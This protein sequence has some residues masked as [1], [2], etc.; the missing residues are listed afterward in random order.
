MRPRGAP[1]YIPAH[2]ISARIDAC[3]Q[4]R[5]SAKVRCMGW[6]GRRTLIISTHVGC[7]CACAAAWAC[8]PPVL[9]GDFLCPVGIRLLG[10][11]LR[12]GVGWVSMCERQ[13]GFWGRT[14]GRTDY[15]CQMYVRLPE[16]EYYPNNI[17]LGPCAPINP[18]LR[19]CREF[20]WVYTLLTTAR[21]K[22]DPSPFNCLLRL[23]V[24]FV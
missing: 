12:W 6:N 3:T 9:G 24:A 19:P 1:R 18:P 2:G 14:C 13:G 7:A 5:P 8:V 23:A 11:G 22:G 4:S 21:S 20:C 15:A 16:M 17:A 10:L